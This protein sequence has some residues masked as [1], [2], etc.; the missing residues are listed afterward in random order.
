MA[1]GRRHLRS[2]GNVRSDTPAREASVT[3]HQ[4][5]R[6]TMSTVRAPN[7]Y[8]VFRLFHHDSNTPSLALWPS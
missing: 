3:T 7:T 1:E 5:E 6:F 8:H 2:D 4:T